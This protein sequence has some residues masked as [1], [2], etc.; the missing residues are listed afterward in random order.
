MNI[1]VCKLPTNST[2]TERNT[3]STCR[4][5]YKCRYRVWSRQN[6]HR[7]NIRWRNHAFICVAKPIYRNIKQR[8]IGSTKAC[9]ILWWQDFVRTR[10]P[11]NR[12]EHVLLLTSSQH[13]MVGSLLEWR[14][15]ADAVQSC[16]LFTDWG[17]RPFSLCSLWNIL[18][19]AKKAFSDGGHRKKCRPLNFKSFLYMIYTGI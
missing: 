13:W 7:Y 14:R 1:P 16:Y 6:L 5:S 18:R 3:G 10:V 12:F 2:C 15:S 17:S 9:R 19:V 4:S 11:V 8:S